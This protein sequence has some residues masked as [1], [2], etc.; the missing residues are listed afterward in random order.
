MAHSP[1]GDDDRNFRESQTSYCKL[2]ID[3]FVSGRKIKF[4]IYVRLMNDRYVKVAHKGE[5]ISI[6]RL[7]AYKKKG[8]AFL[9]LS[10]DDFNA[11]VGFNLEFSDLRKEG[12]QEGRARKL[13]LMQ[14]S[15]EILFKK[16]RHEG[17]DPYVFE[18]AAT[19]V[20]ASL[21]AL[22]DDRVALDMLV[23]LQ[24]H[25][26]FV[27]THCLGVSVY[28]VMISQRIKWSL[29]TNKFKLALG[30][31]LHDIGE[32]ELNQHMLS[33][34][35]YDWSDEDWKAYESHVLLGY[36][37]LKEIKSIPEDVRQI[38]K[39]HHENCAAKGF[40]FQTKK[41]AIHPMAKLIAVADEF[42]YKILKT[43]DSDGMLP[44]EAI[45]E[46]TE[47]SADLFDKEYLGALEE[48]FKVP[49]T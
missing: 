30:G 2:G 46:L 26:D 47:R 33:Q 1:L 41:I 42:C 9:Y 25:S 22:T 27:F 7:R 5:D 28:S 34:S 37:M 39:Q 49:R 35:K 32:K 40:P 15:A 14:A 13:A 19:F 10:Q 17:V 23:A 24:N 18:A 11:Y 48:I 12:D 43:P 31:L 20:E 21:G 4:S 44:V 38:V 36:E 45:Q 3:D 8:L 6:D 29:P 16:I